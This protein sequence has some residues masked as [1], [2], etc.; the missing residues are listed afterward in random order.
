MRQ[1]FITR[2]LSQSEDFTIVEQLPIN[3]DLYRKISKI[4]YS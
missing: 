2:T 1:N 4:S 3:K